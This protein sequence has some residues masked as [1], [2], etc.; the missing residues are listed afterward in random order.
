MPKNLE[1]VVMINKTSFLTILRSTVEAD[2][3]EPSVDIIGKREF[4]GKGRII[5]SIKEAYPIIT[6]MMKPT[7]VSYGNSSARNR[8]I[9]LNNL[10]KSKKENKIIG[11]F[12]THILSKRGFTVPEKISE[13]D[14]IAALGEM[15]DL[16]LRYYFIYLI[17]GLKRYSYKKPRGNSLEIEIKNKELNTFIYYQDKKRIYL[18]LKAFKIGKRKKDDKCEAYIKKSL[19]IEFS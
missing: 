1:E 9:A 15:K 16:N 2:S 14:L 17:G 18:R 8:L 4:D 11:N 10:L 5:Y 6:A 19:P 3:K 12:H 7:E 13:E